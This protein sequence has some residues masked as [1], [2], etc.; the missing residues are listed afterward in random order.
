MLCVLSALS[1]VAAGD[2]G[3]LTRELSL[4][5]LT[6]SFVF[7]DDERRG[8]EPIAR[9]FSVLGDHGTGVGDVLDRGR[10]AQR[11]GCAA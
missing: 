7:A 1:A 10:G 8:F 9:Y 2:C 3:R 4:A 5:E 11:C 6:G